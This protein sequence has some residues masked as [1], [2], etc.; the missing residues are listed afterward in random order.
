MWHTPPA[1]HRAASLP[2]HV[3]KAG[4][5][6]TSSP[7]F[8][9][10]HRHKTALCCAS[11]AE[12]GSSLPGGQPSPLACQELPAQS[13]QRPGFSSGTGFCSCCFAYHCCFYRCFLKGLFLAWRKPVKEHP[14]LSHS[15]SLFSTLSTRRL[16]SNE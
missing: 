3:H 13:C 4:H 11:P 6:P 5:S 10:I 12:T 15:W 1:T 2:T 9:E 7:S 16:P 8:A 14:A